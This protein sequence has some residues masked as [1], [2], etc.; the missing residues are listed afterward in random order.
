[1]VN[2]S[3]PVTVSQT[4]RL[5]NR[6]SIIL[7][8][9]TISNMSHLQGGAAN[10]GLGGLAAGYTQAQ[11]DEVRQFNAG[12]T[13]AGNKSRPNR[14]GTRGRG[15]APTPRSR[16][17]TLT[18]ANSGSDIGYVLMGNYVVGSST[19]SPIC[20]HPSP[21]RGRSP[22][23]KQ[24]PVRTAPTSNEFALEKENIP[25]NRISD[26]SDRTIIISNKSDG[27]STP[28]IPAHL[29]QTSARQTIEEIARMCGQGTSTV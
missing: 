20:K 19:T 22:V 12:L 2:P 21:P 4:A 27:L 13:A 29:H 23:R 3:T 9:P 28:W 16:V 26:Y 11:I 5:V 10:R 6:R 7:Q 17:S 8:H 18:H 1:V 24:S 14:G 15:P 25:E